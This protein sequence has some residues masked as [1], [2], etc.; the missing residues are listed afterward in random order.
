MQIAD[1]ELG[2]WKGYW[3]FPVIP[4]HTSFCFSMHSYISFDVSD[5]SLDQRSAHLEACVWPWAEVG[6]RTLVQTWGI[7][8]DIF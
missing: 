1:P 2:V 8:S 5:A 3:P 6:Q 7:I 4:F